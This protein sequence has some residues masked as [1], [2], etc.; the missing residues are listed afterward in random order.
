MRLSKDQIRH[1][2]LV[3]A[4][5]LTFAFYGTLRMTQLQD[6]A[7]LYIGLPMLLA[8][9]VA[10]IETKNALT[11]IYK[12]L[13]IA[14]FLSPLLIGEGFI[15]MLLASPIMYAV[16]TIVG[17]LIDAIRNRA[18]KKIQAAA[19]LTLVFMLALEGTVP[20]ATIDRMNEVTVE[21][22]VAMNIDDVRQSLSGPMK[23]DQKPKSFYT[24]LFL[25]PDRVTG[26]GLNAGDRRVMTLTYNK[27]IVTNKWT[28]DITFEVADSG[29]DFVTFRLVEDKSYM[30]LYMDWQDATTRFERIDDNHTRVTQTIRYSRKLDPSWYFGP[31]E[32]A[33]V[34]DAAET[35]ID[36]L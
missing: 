33:A 17:L 5:G 31:M 14:I 4:L 25:P 36:S 28:G 9:S 6:T 26:E 20:L 1:L 15:C 11:T 32:R 29:K 16:A 19:G 2:L 10:L 34:R 24:W 35:I 22:T 18:Q 27:W 21:K 13:G 3:L 12:V 30:A 23:Y 8:A 7:A